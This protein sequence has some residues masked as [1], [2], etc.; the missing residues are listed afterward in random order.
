[1]T[2]SASH[3]NQPRVLHLLDTPSRPLGRPVQDGDLDAWDGAAD[4]CAL[5]VERLGDWTHEV[6]II[7]DG[8]SEQRIDR[9]VGGRLGH[10]A[11]PGGC[12]ALAWRGVRSVIRS[13]APF[14]V[15]A[16]WSSR[17]ARLAGRAA[18]GSRVVAIGGAPVVHA[19]GVDR[20]LVFDDRDAERWQSMGVAWERVTAPSCATD[21]NSDTRAALRRELGI[22]MDDRVIVLAGDPVGSADVYR[23]L[24]TVG[25]LSLQN[26][27]LTLVVPKRAAQIDRAY[28]MH[29]AINLKWPMIET[30]LPLTTLLPA[31]DMALSAPWRAETP[32]DGRHAAMV[33]RSHAGGVPVVARDGDWTDDLYGE[34]RE[35]CCCVSAAPSSLASALLRVWRPDDLAG[36][37]AAVREAATAGDPDSAFVGAVERAWSAAITESTSA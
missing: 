28:A 1:M 21:V 37:A 35:R 2:V 30:D 9:V 14:D 17:T 25:I 12:H 27:Q 6:L 24:Y 31:S 8:G 18:A 13:L 5:L 33:R 23:A 19:A 15:I 36:A 16:C 26:E 11:S 7:G 20:A 32:P 3:G 34:A 29:R 10:L 4:C 22:G